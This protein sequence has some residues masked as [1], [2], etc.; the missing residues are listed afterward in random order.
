LVLYDIH[1][2]ITHTHN[3]HTHTHLPVR[4]VIR[5]ICVQCVTAY[6]EGCLY[7]VVDVAP[8]NLAGESFVGCGK[9]VMSAPS[10]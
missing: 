8:P 7:L 10:L 9:Q 1:G 5:C 2:Y 3:T 6:R 4:Y